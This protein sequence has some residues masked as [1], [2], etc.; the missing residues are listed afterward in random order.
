M[1]TYTG[2]C[3]CGQVRYEVKA[4]LSSVMECNCSHCSAKGLL[5][6]FVPEG[7]FKLSS[8]ADALTEYLFNKKV[9]R[10]QFCKHCGVEPFARGRG[11]DGKPTVALN[12]RCLEGVDVAT[13]A[14]KPFDGKKL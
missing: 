12:V 1:Q 3:H 4:D 6:T 9:I 11:P 2:R 5:L 7:D 10:H 8:G 13:L 14:R